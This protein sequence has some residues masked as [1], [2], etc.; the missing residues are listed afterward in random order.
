LVF[1]HFSLLKRGFS[2]VFGAKIPSAYL[3]FYTFWL[4]TPTKTPQKC[5]N[6]CSTRFSLKTPS[7]R[8]FE[9]VL[10]EKRQKLTKN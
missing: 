5:E 8:S 10:R 3:D 4:K 9:G 7:K 6:S 2:G 1:T